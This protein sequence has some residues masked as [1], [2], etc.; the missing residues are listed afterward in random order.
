MAMNYATLIKDLERLNDILLIAR[1]ILVSVRRAQN[2]AAESG[3]DKQ[4][5]R[6]IDLCI[7]VTARGYDGEVRSRNETQWTNIV[8]Y[9]ESYESNIPVLVLHGV[10]SSVIPFR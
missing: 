5:F 8:H 4:V 3:F 6:L 2:L 1:N 9:C 10:T 7:R